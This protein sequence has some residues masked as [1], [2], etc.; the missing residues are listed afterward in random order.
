M[1]LLTLLIK[2]LKLLAGFEQYVFNAHNSMVFPA[3]VDALRCV[4]CVVRMW[5]ESRR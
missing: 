3:G 4:E 5:L 1:L 2:N